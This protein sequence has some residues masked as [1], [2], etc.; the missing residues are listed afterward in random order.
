VSISTAHCFTNRFTNCRT[1]PAIETFFFTNPRDLCNKIFCRFY[2]YSVSQIN[3]Y[4]SLK[5]SWSMMRTTSR[6]E[7]PERSRRFGR[8]PLCVCCEV[9][10]PS[11]ERPV[12]YGQRPVV[13]KDGC[14]SCRMGC[15]R[16]WAPEELIHLA[17][18]YVATT[19]KYQRNVSSGLR[20]HG[21]W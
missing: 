11:C 16:E 15:G 8:T 13:G 6:F 18:A 17:E 10:T 20:S 3:V 12:C 9:A 2:F 5:F 14:A 21:I 1:N 7:S 4:F 19:M